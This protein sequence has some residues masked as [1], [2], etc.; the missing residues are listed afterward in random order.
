VEARLGREV[1]NLRLYLAR[2][3]RKALNEHAQH[4][5]RHRRDLG[6]GLELAEHPHDRRAR[7]RRR[8]LVE[9][10][11]EPHNERVVV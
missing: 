3:A 1:N 2:L 8:D 5:G 7:A 10:L 9:P 11:Y 6:L 4:V